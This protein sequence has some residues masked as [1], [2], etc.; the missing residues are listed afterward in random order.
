MSDN[1]N[2][3]YEIYLTAYCPHCSIGLKSAK[4]GEDKIA[5]KGKFQEKELDLKINPYLDFFEI[6]TS[7][8]IS[9]DTLLDDISCPSCKKSLLTDEYEDENGCKAYAKLIV[10]SDKKLLP[11]YLPL[12]FGKP[13][14]GLS[15]A[16]K[17]KMK[18]KIPRQKMP[19]QDPNL[20]R[21]NFQE[22][23]HGLPSELALLEAQ[24][25]LQCKN[26]PCVKGCPVEVDIPAF[27]ALIKEAD[28]SGAARKIK[29]TN[30]LPAVCGRVCPQEDQCEGVC[31]LQK[32]GDAP[33]A[34][35]NL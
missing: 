34:I 14:A 27:I 31:I 16:D 33:F 4:R 26:A 23:P 30:I 5:L 25:C 2:M 8:E 15:K 20:R 17:R 21:N 13:F 10:A 22:V 1:Q 6:S 7:E 19:E 11:V 28:F 32:M 9:E 29:E 3:T 35:G 12:K 24:R 18:P